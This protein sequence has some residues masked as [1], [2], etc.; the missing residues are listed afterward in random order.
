MAK[1]RKVSKTGAV[2][3]LSSEEAT[4]AQNP[5]YNGFIV[6]HGPHT[7]KKKYSRKFKYGDNFE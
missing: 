1:K 5:R 7:N 6:G 3:K 2:W 4:L